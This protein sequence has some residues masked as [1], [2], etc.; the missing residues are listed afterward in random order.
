MKPSFSFFCLHSPR[1]S[2]VKDLTEKFNTSTE[3]LL[4]VLKTPNHFDSH[5]VMDGMMSG[6]TIGWKS[7]EV[8]VKNPANC[9]VRRPLQKSGFCFPRLGFGK[10]YLL[11]S[12]GLCRG[13]IGSLSHAS[14]SHQRPWLEYLQNIPGN[15]V[16]YQKSNSPRPVRFRRCSTFFGGS[17]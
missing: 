5:D 10:V 16:A 9:P 12:G 6:G 4:Q 2:H 1:L 15:A 11:G 14:F 17:E 8:H 3:R 13:V 7:S